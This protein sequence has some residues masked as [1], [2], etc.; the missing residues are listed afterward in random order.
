M[1]QLLEELA[2]ELGKLGQYQKGIDF[3]IACSKSGVYV[4]A[5]KTNDVDDR[6]ILK[7]L[8]RYSKYEPKINVIANEFISFTL[9]GELDLGAHIRGVKLER[10]GDV[11]LAETAMVYNEETIALVDKIIDREPN[12][13]YELS[14]VTGDTVLIN[15]RKVDVSEAFKNI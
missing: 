15:V 5:L 12:A 6:A 14:Q 7:V 4:N 2:V 13:V 8:S 11:Y 3:G 9:Y 1:E 10:K